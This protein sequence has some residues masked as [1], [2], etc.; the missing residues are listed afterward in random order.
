MAAKRTAKPGKTNSGEKA[1]RHGLVT[2]QMEV[3]LPLQIRALR[4]QRGWSQPE[5]AAAAGMKQPRISAM[6]QPGKVRFSLE[7]LRRM[8]EAFDVALIVRFAPFSELRAWSRSFAP[9][10]FAVPSFEEES[11]VSANARKEAGGGK[12]RGDKPWQ[13]LPAP[14]K[15]RRSR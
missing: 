2:A 14:V 7:T 6:E 4:K 13:P 12:R 3:D 5:L 11:R 1:Y 15:A 8:A 9:D 10:E